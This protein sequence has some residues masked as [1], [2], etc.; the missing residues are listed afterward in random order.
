MFLASRGKPVRFAGHEI[1]QMDRMAIP[2]NCEVVVD[3]A[4]ERVYQNEAAVI[5]VRKPGRI[6]LSDGSAV[7]AVA[8]WDV[9]DLPRTASHRVESG[10]CL[11]EIYHKYRTF[12]SPEFATEDSFTGNAGMIVSEVDANRRRY[13]CSN[14]P[15]EFSP[16]DLVFE[17]SWR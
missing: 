8:I 14:G 9:P 3:F 12:H 4:G 7:K 5:A 15:G 2:E 1:I 6:F 17:V 13:Q 11:L 16:T 10:G